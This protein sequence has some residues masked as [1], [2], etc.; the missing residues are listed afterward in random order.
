MTSASIPIAFPPVYIQVEGNG[1]RYDEMHVD[2]GTTSQV[3]LYPVGL[4]WSTV[5]EKMEVRGMPRA[6]VIRNAKLTPKWQAVDPGI[7]GQSNRVV[8]PAHV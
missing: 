1:K 2:G 8:E 4:D 6:F 5:M 3:F 7:A